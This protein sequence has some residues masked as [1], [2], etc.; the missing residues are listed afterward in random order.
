MLRIQSHAAAAITNYIEEIDQSYIENF[1]SDIY[2]KT[3]A[4]TSENSISI[5]KENALTTLSC[6]A[7]LNSI[8]SKEQVVFLIK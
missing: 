1:G 5:V 2:N 7:Q 6:L 4:L 8:L 3:L